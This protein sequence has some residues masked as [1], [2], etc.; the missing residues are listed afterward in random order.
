[1]Y[2]QLRNRFNGNAS[3]ISWFFCRSNPLWNHWRTNQ[4]SNVWMH[5]SLVHLHYYQESLLTSRG[6]EEGKS[7][8]IR[9]QHRKPNRKGYARRCWWWRGCNWAK[10]HQ[11]RGS[12]PSD[13]IQD[14]VHCHL[15]RLPP[16]LL[17]LLWLKSLKRTIFKGTVAKE[18]SSPYIWCYYDG[19]YS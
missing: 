15:L 19:T 17:S 8:C 18:F 4:G 10:R 11:T 16:H 9:R 7:T 2:H 12:K 6:R 5:C 3:S 1:M 14:Y 13:S